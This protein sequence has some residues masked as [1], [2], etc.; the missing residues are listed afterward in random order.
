MEETTRKKKSRSRRRSSSRTQNK[1]MVQ[2]INELDKKINL[3][4]NETEKKENVKISKNKVIEPK[5]EEKEEGKETI[6]NASK[7]E[8]VDFF[9]VERN[10][11]SSKPNKV[12]YLGYYE[13]LILSIVSFVVFLFAAVY[14]AFQSLEYEPAKNVTYSEKS[15]IDYKI[16]LKENEYYEESCLG[17]EQAE[18]FVA[19]LIETI[20]ISFTYDFNIEENTNVNFSYSIIGKLSITDDKGESVF[21]EKEYVLL[22]KKNVSMTN[23]KNLHIEE[24]IDIDY[25]QYNNLANN[26]KTSYGLDTAS[27]LKVYLILQKENPDNTY[28]FEKSK[29]ILLM[30]PLSEKA[31]SIKLDFENVNESKNLISEDKISLKGPSNIAFTII[32]LILSLYSLYKMICL[33]IMVKPKKSVYDK[34]VDNLL[35]EYDRLIVETVTAP[36]LTDDDIIKV[37]NFEEL[38]DVRYNLKLPIMYY[39]ITPHHKCCFYIKHEN[40][41]YLKTIKA[42]DLENQKQ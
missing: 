22:N 8:K 17:K 42:V 14:F 29:D 1:T 33:T 19:N 37:K 13:R 3:L 25:G 16:C 20:P 36:D 21:L 18:L 15:N 35:K 24:N 40:N 34:Y 30:I 26:F 12:L 4:D 28:E 2:K 11:D 32:L 9:N 31:V 38:L 41:V 6:E 7:E 39:V 5:K 10:S 27:N 23:D